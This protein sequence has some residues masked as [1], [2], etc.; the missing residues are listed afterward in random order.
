MELDQLEDTT[1]NTVVELT[2][3]H[4]GPHVIANMITENGP[5]YTSHELAKF[6]QEWEFEH[7]TSSPQYTQSNW[8]AESAVKIAKTLLKKAKKDNKDINFVLLECRNT[9]ARDNP[10]PAPKL[11]SRRTRTT[12]PTSDALYV[13]QVVKSLPE[14]N[15]GEPVRLQPHQPKTPWLKGSCLTKHGPRSYLVQTEEGS[16]IWRHRKFIRTDNSQAIAHV[17]SVPEENIQPN[18]VFD[19][20][21]EISIQRT[22]P[23]D[24]SLEVQV[25]V[26]DVDPVSKN[27]TEPIQ[28]TRSGRIPQ[29]YKDFVK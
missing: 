19:Q 22:D 20:P 6:K 14:L 8:K 12:M 23:K 1:A 5:Q 18:P 26:S 25:P 4:F 21:H 28:S 13:P 3:S 10:S 24:K 15:I 2:K 9:P 16:L 29:K 27:T 7:T 11:F 17:P